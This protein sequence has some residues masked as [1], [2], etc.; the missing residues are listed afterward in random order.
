MRLRIWGIL[1]RISICGCVDTGESFGILERDETEGQ[2]KHFVMNE[3]SSQVK[4]QTEGA[5]IIQ[6]SLML[7]EGKLF[8][9]RDRD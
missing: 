4:S 7:I 8:P 6:M 2:S 3:K 1:A 9:D 5:S